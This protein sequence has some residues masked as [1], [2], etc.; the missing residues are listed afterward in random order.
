MHRQMTMRLIAARIPQTLVAAVGLDHV[1]ISPG[2]RT[3]VTVATRTYVPGK[4]NLIHLVD[5]GCTCGSPS[6]CLSAPGVQPPVVITGQVLL[7]GC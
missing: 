5:S 7:L 1:T 6:A 2:K 4:A 3:Y